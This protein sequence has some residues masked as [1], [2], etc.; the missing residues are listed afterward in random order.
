MVRVS[1]TLAGMLDG[2]AAEAWDHTVRDECFDDEGL[3]KGAGSGN[4]SYGQIEA[5]FRRPCIPA[6]GLGVR[7]EQSLQIQ[8]SSAECR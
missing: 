1:E 3:H 5:H 4:G 2:A 7:R 6:L 8:L